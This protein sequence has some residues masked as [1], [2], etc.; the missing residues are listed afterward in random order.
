MRNSKKN[1]KI[2]Q[3]YFKKRKCM[4]VY[5]QCFWMGSLKILKMSDCNSL[6][7]KNNAVTIIIPGDP[8]SEL[9]KMSLKYLGEKSTKTVKKV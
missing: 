4:K 6:I 8:F 2:L 5:V 1:H 9:H 3:S 7:N